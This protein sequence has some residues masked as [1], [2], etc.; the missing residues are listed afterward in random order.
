MITLLHG[1]DELA[2]SEALASI[3]ATIPADLADL[4][5][6]TLDGRKLK[7]DALVAACEAFPFIA[8]QR[9]VIVYDMLKHLK[10]GKERDEIRAYLERVPETCQLVLVEREEVDKRNAIFTFLKKASDKG[11]AVVQEF[12]PRE[13]PALRRWLAERA[14]ALDVTLEDAAAQRLVDYVGGEGRALAN[15]LNKLASYVGRGGQITP[16]VVDRLTQNEQEQKLFGFIDELSQRRRGAALQSLRRLFADGQAAPYVLFMVARQARLLL[17]VKELTR[18]RLRPD[19]MAKQ[20]GQQPFVVRKAA[21]QARGFSD[22]ELLAL[23]SRLLELD[24]AT[25]TG[26]MEPE[27]GLEMLVIETCR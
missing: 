1:S 27:T 21:E 3:K 18:Q 17:N 6:T 20:L 11:G 4:N 9:L 25:K 8:E 26:R 19:E 14:H 12:Q 5:S 15:E 10:A 23:H 7:P 13:G 24:H 2:R 16:A 22:E